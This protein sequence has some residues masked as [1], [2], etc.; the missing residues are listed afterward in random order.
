MATERLRPLEDEAWRGFLLTHDRI[1]R[2]IQ[3]GLAP[4]N[5]SMAEYSVLALLGEAA[6]EP[7][8]MSELAERRLMSTGGFT[9]L[10]D[11][12]EKR[13]LIER[14]RSAADGRGFEVTLTDE[15]RDLL[16]KAW[17]QQYG[18]IR[19]LF[20]DRLGEDDLR[21]LADIWKR[22]AADPE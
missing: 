5:V 18:D 14:R 20:L 11:R 3:E 16:R 19:R 6:P 15:G 22:L 12:L 9:R 17:R 21:V 8:R 2:S 13:G 1:W 4:L 7:M 10:A